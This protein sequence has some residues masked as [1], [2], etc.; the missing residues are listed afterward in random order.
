MF[1]AFTN[2]ITTI[3]RYQEIQK[4]LAELAKKDVLVGIPME[5]SSRLENSDQ[6]N[7]AELAYIHTHGIRRRPMREEMQQN[8]DNNNLPYSTAF[9]MYLQVHGSPLWQSPPRPIIEPAIEHH[10]DEIASLLQEALIKALECK[11]FLPAL[12][13]AGMKGQNVARGWFTNPL[14]Q[15]PP[16][17]PLTVAEKGSDKPLIDTGELRKS[18][19]YVIRDK[20]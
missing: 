15:W 7:N 18:I 20:G 14:N 10:K 4:S 16:N 11:D 3:D 9:Q 12:K 8:M 13:K 2:V 19:T 17:S 1:Q 5:K 6:I